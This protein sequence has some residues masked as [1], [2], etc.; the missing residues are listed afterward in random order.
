MDWTRVSRK[1]KRNRELGPIAKK[2]AVPNAVP[3]LVPNFVEQAIA[4]LRVHLIAA[5]EVSWFNANDGVV[6]CEPAH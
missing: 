4:W 6:L 3:P 2:H 5:R 1:A